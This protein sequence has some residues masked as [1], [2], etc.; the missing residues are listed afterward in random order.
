MRTVRRLARCSRRVFSTAA[1][2]LMTL[3]SVHAL[4]EEAA[5]AQVDAVQPPSLAAAVEAAYPPAALDARVEATVELLLTIDASGNVSSAEV[6]RGGGAE[7]GGA[8]KE[9]VLQYRFVPARRNGIPVAARVRYLYE[10]KLPPEASRQAT[11]GSLLVR[12]TRDGLP[13][14]GVL[15]TLVSPSSERTALATDGRG[16]ARWGELRPGLYAAEA[17]ADGRVA[18]ASTEVGA[19]TESTLDLQVAAPAAKAVAPV[20]IQVRGQATESERLQRS[21]EAVNVVELR[22][23]KQQTVDLGE[24]LARTQ[25]VAV[26]RTGGLGSNTRFALNGLY[27]EQVRFFVDG[28]PLDLAGYPFGVANIPV[29]ILERVEVYRGVVPVRFGADALG[30]AVNLVTD[31]SYKTHAGVSYQIGSFGTHRLSLNARYRHDPS[32]VIVGVTGFFDRAKNDYRIEVGIPAPNGRLVQTEV[33]RF[34]DGYTA[35]GGS[36]EIGVIDRRWAKRLSLQVFASTYRKELQSNLT[37]TVPYGEVRYGGTSYGA[38][39]RYEVALHER[40]D[41]ELLANYSRTA[42]EL[43]D[44]SEWIYGWRGNRISQRERP[45][46]LSVLP[47][48]QVDYQ[49]SIYGRS[50]LKWKVATHHQFSLS[51]TPNVVTRHFDNRLVNDALERNPERR[52]STVVSGL[53]YEADAFEERLSNIVFVK[54]YIYRAKSAQ[55]LIDG[56]TLARGADSHTLGAGDS[57]R[58]RLTPWLY[59]KASYEYATR[60]PRP[61]EVFG[62]GV[63]VQANLDLKPEVSHNVNVG[64]RVE[65]QRT[66]LGDFVFDVNAFLRDSD[67]LILLL[68]GIDSDFSGF[69]N[70]YRARTLGVEN[71]FA[72]VA[73]RRLAGLDATLTWLDSRN[74]STFGPFENLNGDRIPNR[75]YL[76]ASWGARLRFA[77]KAHAVEPF[78]HGRYVHEFFRAW[79]SL[80]SADFKQ[81]VPSQLAHS[82]GASWTLTGDFGRLTSTLEVDNFTNA[83]LF[84]NFGAQRPGRAFYLKGVVRSDHSRKQQT[85]PRL[86]D[87]HNHVREFQD[88]PRCGRCPAHHRDRL[89]QRRQE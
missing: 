33:S 20:E 36:L 51:V 47:A 67:R 16:E 80:G 72:W 23:A 24:V 70:L 53:E 45:G 74:A 12:L 44:Q 42:I 28:V 38:T 58:Y 17:T 78:Y 35:G 69:Q 85:K 13:L 60:L 64:P 4:A 55:V 27:D 73:P 25:G 41:L 22:K 32:G 63:L 7:F 83:K 3:A 9:A 57:L 43:T 31:P 75:P 19:G 52:L 87:D 81:T 46:E 77:R 48:D 5:P 62:N 66:R 21:A 65:L 76:F 15:V 50:T 54:D 39:A 2:A 26:R 6:L 49:D 29:S 82:V 18:S 8:A 89:R 34:H 61:D 37:M 1:F 79:E 84:D 68:G 88:G 56:T 14:S 59:A 40:V 86:H 10:F 71:A 11:F 30:G